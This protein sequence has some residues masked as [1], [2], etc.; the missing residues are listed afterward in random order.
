MSN[1]ID[2]NEIGSKE[3]KRIEE[4]KTVTI[5]EDE[6]RTTMA[7]ALSDD[8]IAEIVKKEPLMFFPFAAYC[9]AVINVLFHKEDDK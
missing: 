8:R 3:G 9:A 1:Y 7:K 4:K 5:T 6:L 2:V